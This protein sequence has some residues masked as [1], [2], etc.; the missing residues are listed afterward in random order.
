MFVTVTGLQKVTK[1]IYIEDEK[2]FESITNF[3]EKE[4]YLYEVS[5]QVQE[6]EE[7]IE[8]SYSAPST[9]EWGEE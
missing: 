4:E 9:E 8:I 7:I 5:S 6:F 1:V 3:D 2:E